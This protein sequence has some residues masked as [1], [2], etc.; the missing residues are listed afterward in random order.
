[1]FSVNRP[2][3]VVVLND[4][5][6]ETN[7]TPF[8]SNTLDQLGEVGQRAAE[9][10]DLVD[11]DHVDQPVLDILEQP[12]STRGVQSVPP[13][14][15]PSSYWSR[16]STQPSDRWL[17]MYASHASRWAWRLLNSC[18]SPSSEDFRV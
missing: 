14:M 7:V 11:H 16:T 9:A 3:E 12:F 17:A 2:I 18:S 6:T 5:V 10:V 15:P 8:R 13:E 4:C 1:M